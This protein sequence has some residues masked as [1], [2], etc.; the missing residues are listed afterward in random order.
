ML[1]RYTKRCVL[2]VSEHL[3]ILR[4]L[5]PPS[6]PLPGPGPPPLVPS[7][8]IHATLTSLPGFCFPIV[9]MM[10]YRGVPVSPSSAQFRDEQG[11]TLSTVNFRTDGV[12]IAKLANIEIVTAVL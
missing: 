10:Y 2:S 6:P 8:L 5:P 1:E 4:G 11:L 9:L 7:L 12:D 3:R